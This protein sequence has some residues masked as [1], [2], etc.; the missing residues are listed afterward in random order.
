VKLLNQEVV[1]A[2]PKNHPALLLLPKN[3]DGPSER[4]R[5]GVC[6][7]KACFSSFS[8]N[9]NQD[10]GM[11]KK[12]NGKTVFYEKKKKLLLENEFFFLLDRISWVEEEVL[13]CDYSSSF[14]HET[15]AEQYLGKRACRC[16]S[17]N[18]S[19]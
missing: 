3:N 6:N 7:R 17:I 8:C 4:R 12:A 10:S 11:Y 16:S 15:S 2:P 1:V 14:A 9:P 18:S 5:T 19:D 13:I